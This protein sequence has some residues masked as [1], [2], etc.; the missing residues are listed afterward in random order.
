L[1]YFLNNTVFGAYSGKQY[2]KKGDI[3]SLIS[4][5]GNMAIVD[6]G[7]ERFPVKLERLSKAEVEKHPEPVEINKVEQPVYIKPSG[8][9]KKSVTNHS[10]NIQSLF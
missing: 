6:G 8:K 2:G 7:F 10:N 9:S 1:Q 3:V 4:E 5:H